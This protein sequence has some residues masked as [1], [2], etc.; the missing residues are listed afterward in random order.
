M[1]GFII[2]KALYLIGKALYSTIGNILPRSSSRIGGKIGK[3]FRALCAKLMLEKTGVNINIEKK[4]RFSRRVTV[5]DNSGIGYNTY[6]QGKVEI[7]KNVMMAENVRIFTTNHR[8][9]RTDIPMCQQGAQEERPVVI[10]D[11]VWLCDSVIICPGTKIGNGVIIGAGSVVRGNI[12]DYAVVAGNPAQIV[13]Y[14]GK[15]DE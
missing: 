11:D 2:G 8:T 1:L 3:K 14:R 10:G 5:G 7:G 13:K 12:P 6:L 15:I 9:D 4:A